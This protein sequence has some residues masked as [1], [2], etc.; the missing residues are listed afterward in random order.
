MKEIDDALA[1]FPYSYTLLAAKAEILAKQNK[2]NEAIQFAKL[3]LSHNTENEDM[4]KLIRDLDKT[5]DDIDAVSVKD[6]YKLIAERRSKGK[7]G[8]KGV[9]TLLDEYIV[10]IYQEGG[11]KKRTTYAYEIT[12]EI[13]IEE[14]KEYYVNYYDKVLKSEIVKSNGNIIP[15]EKS[16][17]QIVFTNLSVGDVVLIQ[18]ESIERNS[19][20]FNKDFNLSSYFNSEYP[21][22]ESVFT[23]ITPENLNYQVKSNNR[24]VVSTKKKMGSKMY[25]TWKLDNLEEVSLDEYFGPSYY[26]ATISVTANSIK[27]WQEISNWYADVTRKSLVSDKVVDEDF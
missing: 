23:V 21:V 22:V 20:R 15:G 2:K 4:H 6:L 8:K 11:L 16:E 13:G 27:T 18:K 25:Q 9:T 10:D 24:E 1:N 19:G 7:K 12:S 17:D 14:L 5:T 26:D 3:S